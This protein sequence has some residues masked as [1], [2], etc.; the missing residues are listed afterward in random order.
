MRDAVT[1]GRGRRRDRVLLALALA[2]ALVG[3][4]RA[5]RMSSMSS[6]PP[7]AMVAPGAAGG[8]TAGVPLADRAMRITVETTIQVPRRDEAAA[9]LRAAVA[10]VGGYV[11]E[12]TLV[13]QDA[14]GS[15]AFTLKIPVAALAGFRAQLARLGEVE[16]DSEKAEDVT[17]ARADLKARLHNARAAEQRLLELLA[18]RTGNLG[19]VVAVEKELTSVRETIERLDAEERTLEGEIAFATVKARLETLYVPRQ[20]GLGRRLAEAGRDGLESGQAFLVGTLTFALSAGPTLLILA[21]MGYA[22]FAAVRAWMRRRRA[23]RRPA[24]G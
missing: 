23:A 5:S 6:P 11:S 22:A 1:A 7:L 3:C 13:G 10:A 14:G 4:G 16:S 9:A 21:A 18:G 19:D 8:A 2:L 15:A 20:A 24:E 17:E 12:G